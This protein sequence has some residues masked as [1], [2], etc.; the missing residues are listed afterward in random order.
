MRHALSIFATLVLFTSLGAAC[1]DDDPAPASQV[2]ADAAAA[3]GASDT[4]PD[5]EPD[6]EADADAALTDT[7]AASV[8]AEADAPD[9]PA[10][11]APPEGPAPAA[12]RWSLSMFHFNIQY[13][14]GGLEG[15]GEIAFGL[16]NTE[17]VF[18]LNAEEV[19]DLIVSESVA[20]V[21][22]ILER[23]PDLALTFE[24][25]GYMVDVIRERH[26]ETLA[27][28]RALVEGGQL[29]LASIHW[30]DQF[31]L[32]FGVEDMDESWRRTEASFAAAGLPLSRAVFTQEGQFGEGFA[33]W[34][35]AARPDA[36]MVMARNIQRFF[37][38]NLANEALWRV[39]ALDVVL[40]RGYGD[41]RVAM[42]WNFFDDGELLATGDLNPYVGTGFRANAGAIARYERELRCL[43]DEGV[44]VGRLSDYVDAVRAEGI[45]PV[46]MP[47]FMDATWQPRSTRGPLRW[48]GGAGQVSARHEAD[49]Q[50]L[51]RCV[52]ARH[53]V[54]A[55]AT[56]LADPATEATPTELAALDTG[57]QELLWGQVSDA[58]GVNPWFGE[59]AYGR[60]HC[61]AARSGASAALRAIAARRGG[62]L[63]IDTDSGAVFV[64]DG[65]PEEE[66]SEPASA[67]IE[68]VV[69][70]DGGRVPT[71]S[72]SRL[73]PGGPFV[74]DVT[75]PPVEGAAASFDACLVAHPD[76]TW[77][78]AVEPRPI[79]LQFPREPGLMGYRP[80]L[81]ST[82][83][84]YTEA[85]FDLQ[86][87]ASTDAVWSTAAD[88]LIDL[89]ADRFV[90]K[91]TRAVHLAV[92][93]KAGAGQNGVVELRDEVTQPYETERWRFFFAADVAVAER[94]ADRNL[95]PVI[96]VA[97]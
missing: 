23:N 92:G 64:L 13:V 42:D 62:F 35:A 79:A 48:M 53:Q 9:P 24:M 66:P 40:P 14:A 43:A 11:P 15:F 87:E 70:A 32:A 28:M 84:R 76:K 1:S 38:T 65:P 88:G 37:Q 69:S 21:L 26:P 33:A 68:V 60:Q 51:T 18:G 34:L 67:P 71:L 80:A 82:L 6:A 50:V 54:L 89:G 95:R 20:P 56:A 78:C 55:L 10:C 27:R 7:D 47:P 94:L 90:V 16:Q 19:E 31:F 22:G 72:W 73:L 30:S 97:P 36:I 5:A 61:G 74:L 81:S 75:W 46:A 86:E 63:S 3:D 12:G 59:V 8:D 96:L 93:W 83:V 2:D 44:R 29:E 57:W 85:D 39:G 49:N 45:E 91:D 52:A 4:A 25:Q 77:S 17:E 41:D 58:R